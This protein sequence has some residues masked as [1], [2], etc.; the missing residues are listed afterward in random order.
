[1]T[2][3]DQAV[4]ER[5]LIEQVYATA[6]QPEV[7]RFVSG[8]EKDAMAAIHSDVMVAAGLNPFTK[9]KVTD[10]WA[11]VVSKA[12]STTRKMFRNTDVDLEPIFAS[13]DE[14]DLPGRTYERVSNMIVQ[15]SNEEWDQHKLSR[16]IREAAGSSPVIT[17]AMVT[18]LATSVYSIVQTRR[19]KKNGVKYKK[20]VAHLD[21][22]TRDSHREADGQVQLEFEPFTVGGALMQYPCDMSGPAA[23]VM[24]CRC[25]MMGA[26]RKG[27]IV[28]A[29]EDPLGDFIYI[30]L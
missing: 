17:A 29:E 15:G 23:E 10:R 21:G 1:M 27:E 26:N 30:D 25:L 8:V 16:M 4:G 18:A 28:F 13:L 12:R 3:I 11:K 6:V 14:S 2:T 5:N 22:R 20:W 9:K 19:N 24:N 7:D